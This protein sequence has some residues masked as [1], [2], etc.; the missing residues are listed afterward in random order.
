ME[1]EGSFPCSQQLAIGPCPEPD[2]SSAH[3][4]T[5]PQDPF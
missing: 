3:L 2:T 5:F 4:T 1:P